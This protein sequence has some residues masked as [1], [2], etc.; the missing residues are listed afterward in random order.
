MQNFQGWLDRVGKTFFDNDFD[1]Y[2]DTMILP[3]VMVTA[4]QTMVIQSL[5]QQREGFDAFR[6]LMDRLGATDLFRLGAGVYPVGS[7]ILCGSYETHLLRN[8][9]RL[10]EAFRSSAMLRLGDDG[11][12]RAACIANSL[13]N[14]SW[15]IRTLQSE[16]NDAPLARKDPSPDWMKLARQK[17]PPLP[18]LPPQ[19]GTYDQGDPGAHWP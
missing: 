4:R 9:Q 18:G 10:I 15:P 8:G 17:L 16:A 13:T 6:A 19:A 2:A 3:F 11:I 7:T 14:L 5:D 1:G 12:W